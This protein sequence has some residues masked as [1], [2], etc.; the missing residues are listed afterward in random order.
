MRI[1][2]FEKMFPLDEIFLLI[3][4]IINNDY[5]IDDYSYTNDKNLLIIGTDVNCQSV[6]I[7]GYINKPKNRFFLSII[8]LD[9]IQFLRD[10]TYS[11]NCNEIVTKVGKSLSNLFK[12]IK[13]NQQNYAFT[14]LNIKNPEN[15]ELQIKLIETEKLILIKILNSIHERFEYSDLLSKYP[16]SLSDIDGSWE[17]WYDVYDQYLNL[18]ETKFI[19]N[20]NNSLKTFRNYDFAS[21]NSFSQRI[22]DLIIEEEETI[23]NPILMKSRRRIKTLQE[24]TQDKALDNLENDKHNLNII[25]LFAH[26]KK[27]PLTLI[28]MLKLLGE[29][30]TFIKLQQKKDRKRYKHIHSQIIFIS[31]FGFEQRIGD[32]LKNNQFGNLSESQSILTIPPINNQLWH[33]YFLFNIKE[34]NEYTK[35]QSITNLT[36]YNK[37]RSNFNANRP[38]LR[39]MESQYNDIVESKKVSENNYQEVNDWEEILCVKSCSELLDIINSREKIIKAIS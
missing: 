29:V 9:N 15:R 14:N 16:F 3:K 26:K 35:S 38:E 24:R 33:N 34:E 31:L 4:T 13:E 18:V 17:T 8:V 23:S 37:I 6:I 5:E 2:T 12:N 25:F 28:Q 19:K 21:E 30:K 22:A 10:F 1:Y 32:Y 11:K 27:E 36:K 20:K 39:K 7:R